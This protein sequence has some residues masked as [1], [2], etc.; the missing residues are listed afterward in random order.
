MGSPT[1]LVTY[2]TLTSRDTSEAFGQEI[3][4]MM[5]LIINSIL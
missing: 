5:I 4:T 1:R 2:L 3:E